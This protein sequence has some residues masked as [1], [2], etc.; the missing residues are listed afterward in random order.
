MFLR[1]FQILTISAAA[2]I[3]LLFFTIILQAQVNHG[4]ERGSGSIKKFGY[5]TALGGETAYSIARK[6]NLSTEEFFAYNPQANRGI[7]TG[8]EF[9]IPAP[10]VLNGEDKSHKV[11]Q[12]LKYIVNRRETLYS[13]A[14]IFNT[15]QEEILKLN[16][17]VKGALL[18]G[19]VLVIP[20]LFSQEISPPKPEVTLPVREYLIAAGD[21]YYQLQQKFGVSQAE[22]DQLN[23]GLKDGFKLGMLLKIPLKNAHE[24]NQARVVSFPKGGSG[25]KVVAPP[26]EITPA[27]VSV[28]EKGDKKSAESTIQKSDVN[29]LEK[30]ATEHSAFI[31][32]EPER[33]LNH[34]N[35]EIAILLP[36]CQN[37]SDSARLSLHANNFTEFYSGVLIAAEKLSQTGMN[38]KLFVYDT[39]HDSDVISSL[40]KKPEFLSFDLIIGPVF[41]KD[42]KIIAELSFKNH[43]PMVSP[44]SPDS[45]FGFTTPAYYVIN[46]G[47]RVRLASTADYISDT[48]GSQN[49]I[50]L[51]HGDYSSDEKYL[52][53]KITYKLGSGKVHPYN[54]LTGEA[55]G[56]EELVNDDL[57][58]IFVLAETSEA[59]VSVAMTRLNTISKTHKIKVIGQQEYTKMQSID[60]EYLHNV[61]LQYLT[62]Y[63]IDY[64]SSKV[65][66]FIVKYRSAYG[67]DPSQYSFQG[68]DIALHFITSLGIAGKNF[69]V[70]NPVPAVE[71]LQSEYNF[72]KL[73][74]LGGYLNRTLYVVEYTTGYEVRTIG[75]L[76]GS[77]SSTHPGDER[78]E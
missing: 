69:P 19:T 53:D 49:I 48:F 41:P 76:K 50:I 36:F 17:D 4:D 66:N 18:N 62:P 60:V 40:V 61:N 32:S 16:P 31:Q 47:K 14:K 74:D 71:L 51:N 25:I 65:N 2:V 8:D 55:A 35:F 28:D 38:L 56:L 10:L 12:Q 5:Y 68:Y 22:L 30:G 24:V 58:N 42:Q 29:S 21:N 46:P 3:F 57:E 6:F 78:D 27:K 72:H 54:I 37:L 1:R 7:H 64:G 43:I 20:V 23:P 39:Y 67:T 26:A 34:K 15:T 70:T 77:I 9:R 11:T 45:R 52:L 44:L 63:F 75:K 73:S 59:N 13:I 33:E